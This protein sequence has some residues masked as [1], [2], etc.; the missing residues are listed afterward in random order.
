MHH[1]QLHRPKPLQPGLPLPGLPLQGLPL[2]VRPQPGPRLLLPLQPGR[3]QPGPLLL[4]PRQQQRPQLQQRRR[5]RQLL[6]RR[7]LHARYAFCQVQISS[8]AHEFPGPPSNRR[9]P[10]FSAHARSVARLDQ[11]SRQYARSSMSGAGHGLLEP[12]DYRCPR[13]RHTGHRAVPMPRQ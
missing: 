5:P 2:R 1:W 9:L 8:A 4:A 10:A 7:L 11:A 3:P 13:A 6:Q 12:L